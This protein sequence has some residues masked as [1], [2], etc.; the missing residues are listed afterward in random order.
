MIL[1][2]TVS[3]MFVGSLLL[4]HGRDRRVAGHG[5]IKWLRLAGLLPLALQFLLYMFFGVGEIAGGDP[6]GIVHLLQAV[7]V[8]LMGYLAWLRPLEAGSALT[9]CGIIALVVF[10]A[11]VFHA[12]FTPGSS[13]IST[14]VWLTS[15]PQLV[16]GLLF[17]IAGVISRRRGKTDR[18]EE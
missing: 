1:I 4:R 5:A 9:A 17:L 13:R 12:S 16:S 14:G 18:H 6:G 3:V 2:Y 8:A 7:L 15:M 10:L 11:A